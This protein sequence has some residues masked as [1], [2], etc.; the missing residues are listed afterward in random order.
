MS[1]GSDPVWD[2]RGGGGTEEHR[3]V[4]NVQGEAKTADKIPRLQGGSHNR[5]Y[6]GASDVD[7]QDRDRNKLKPAVG[8]SKI[9]P[10]QHVPVPMPLPSLP[11][12]IPYL[13]R[14]P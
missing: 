7:E 8:Q 4:E 14:P 10:A 3:E 11:G 6:D 13:K 1:A 9:T 12:F 2:V 5:V